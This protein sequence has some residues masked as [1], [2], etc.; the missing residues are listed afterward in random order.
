MTTVSPVPVHPQSSWLNY[1]QG[2]DEDL[3]TGDPGATP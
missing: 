1:W 3:W 2:R